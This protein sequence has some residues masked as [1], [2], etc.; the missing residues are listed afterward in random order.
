[1]QQFH[2]DW[3]Q[4]YSGKKFYLPNPTEDMIDIVDIAHALSMMCRFNGHVKN[5]YSVAEHSVYVSDNVPEEHQLAALL[6][7][8]SEAYIADI[9]SP[10]KKMLGN[11]AELEDQIMRVIAKKFGFEYPLHPKIHRADIAQ[12]RTEAILLMT[13]YPHW[14]DDVY[15]SDF[16]DTAGTVPIVLSPQKAESMFINRYKEILKGNTDA[17]YFKSRYPIVA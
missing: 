1:M 9:A 13:H 14:V 2:F 11:Y 16:E 6:H 15:Y 5:F 8:A 17:E 4:T 7:D 10:F 12:L 3:I